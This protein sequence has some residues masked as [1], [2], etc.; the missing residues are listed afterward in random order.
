MIGIIIV[1][2]TT[3]IF[4]FHSRSQLQDVMN[5]LYSISYHDTNSSEVN[6]GGIDNRMTIIDRR[7]LTITN[8]GWNHPNHT[9]ALSTGRF[10]ASADF[11]DAVTSHPRYNSSAWMMLSE[12]PDP[13]RPIIAFLDIETCGETCWPNMNACGGINDQNSDVRYNRPLLIE[14]TADDVCGQ[15]EKV[16]SSPAMSAMDSR[17]VALHCQPGDH[18]GWGVECGGSERNQT[19]F[20]KLIVAHQTSYKTEG[21]QHMDMGLP[22]LPVKPVTLNATELN[23]IMSSCRQT[24]L[25]DKNQT[26]RPFL[27]SFKGRPRFEEFNDYF[28]PLHGTH[29]IYAQFGSDHYVLG[30]VTEILPEKQRDDAYMELLRSSRF[31]GAPRGDNLYSYRFS[32]ILSAGTIP[33]VYADGWMLPY[34]SS[35]VKWEDVVVF[36]PQSEVNRTLDTLM[37][38]DN[39]RIC[40]MQQAILNFYNE[41]VND[42][43][44]RLRGILKVLEGRLAQK[45]D[46]SYVPGDG[47]PY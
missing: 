31:A 45:I 24:A 17:L 20:G 35:I 25:P 46:Y 47:P 28:A 15:I 4:Y 26:T 16:L 33:V 3:M 21:V 43:Y 36:I 18:G 34:T 12:R 5:N 39:F 10:K 6:H 30:N 1:I 8:L 7:E 38:Y 29:G 27:F 41:Y 9:I 37:T 13:T 14:Y 23:D 19:I 22:P 40:E 2:T 32:D 11:V 42:S 44:G